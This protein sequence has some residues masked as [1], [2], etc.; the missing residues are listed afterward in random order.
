MLASEAQHVSALTAPSAL[1]I[2]QKQQDEPVVRNGRPTYRS[3]PSR[4]SGFRKIRKLDYLLY[5]S[6]VSG[7][8][9]LT[10]SKVT[11]GTQSVRRPGDPT[12]TFR[13]HLAMPAV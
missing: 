9:E 11:R 2:V 10:Y 5:S 7:F 6:D 8:N 3:I 12:G 1:R 13:P 4:R